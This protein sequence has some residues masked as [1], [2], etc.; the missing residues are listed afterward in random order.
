MAKQ[1]AWQ[2][3]GPFFHFALP[4]TGGADLTGDSELGARPDL[5]PPGHYVLGNV[6]R[7]ARRNVRGERIQIEG[8]VRDADGAPVPDAMIE[9]WQ[10]N[11]QG[12]YPSSID[13]RSDLADDPAFV[14]FG[15]CATDVDGHYAFHTIRPGRVPGPGNTLQAPHIA[16]GVLARG[17]LKRLV[18]RIYFSDSATNK[19]DPILALV[20]MDRSDTLI[21]QRKAGDSI[22]Y[23]FDIVLNGKNETVFFDC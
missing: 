17:L 9:I 6:D 20:P 7:A 21:A 10:A 8:Y 23:R 14:G 19:E 18:T 3:I 5:T 12:R 4:W 11:A 22:E 1:T 13:P 16:V 15:R 2:T